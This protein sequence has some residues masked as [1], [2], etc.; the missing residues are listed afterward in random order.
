M[1]RVISAA[2]QFVDGFTRPSRAVIQSMRQMGNEAIKAG[3]QIQNA[4]KTITNAGV[5]VTKTITLP[6]VGVATA[7]VKTAADFE[8]AMSQVAAVSGATGEE[9]AALTEKAKEMG[10]KTKFSASESAAAMN[11]M[12]MAGWKSSDMIDGIEGIMNLA[13]ASGEDLAVTSDI[14]TDALTAFGMSANESKRFAD[15]LAAASSNANT[16]VSMMGETFKYCAPVAGALGYSVEDT[17]EAIG[18]MANSGIKASNAGTAMRAMLTNLQ[19]AVEFSGDSFG[20]WA[21]ETTNADGSMRELNEILTD[22]R[23]AFSHMTESE[24]A[25]NAEALVGKTGMSGFLAVMNAAPADIKKLNTAITN[26]SGAAEKMANIMNDNL[27]GQITILK[28]AIE[29]IAI[30]IGDKLLPY[31]KKGVSWV[32]TAADYIN[33]LSDAQVENIMKWAGIASAVG[34]AVMVFG[35]VVT[36][37]G[38]V[39]STFGKVIKTVASFKGVIGL[40]A[41]PAGIVIGVLAGIALAAFLII[42][43]WEKVKGFLFNVAAWFKEAFQKSGISVEE[44]RSVFSSIGNTT[45]SIAGKIWNLL[46]KAAGKFKEVFGPIIAVCVEKAGN[47]LQSVAAV[48]VRVFYMIIKAVDGGLKIFDALLSFFTGAFSG[49]WK[50][51][52]AGFRTSLKN[53]F[54][55]DIADGIIK[56]FNK[57]L[58]VIIAIVEITKIV[59]RQLGSAAKVIFSAVCGS[60]TAAAS[61]IKPVISGLVKTFKGIITFLKGVFL[62]DW[63]MVWEGLKTIFSGAFE[64]LEGLC[65]VPINAVIGLINGAIAGINKLGLTIPEW[66]PGIGGKSFSINIPPIP[67]LYKGTDNWQGGMAMIHDRGGEIVD[68]PKG[69]R[70]YPHDKSIEMARN[71]G[72]KQSMAGAITLNIQKLADKIEVRNDEDI[73]R[74]AE[75]LA[76]KL[77]KTAFNGG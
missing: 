3:K 16:N 4:G 48:T 47:R 37:V 49:N 73:D 65:K 25:A 35:K 77:K 42:K 51:A 23:E 58:P 7:A 14:V 40:I 61:S 39:T 62:G 57:Y 72:R 50:S 41:S 22:C 45:R 55:P 34:P 56:A 5:S 9:F 46:E 8:S 13:A 30:T 64:A 69:S 63:G 19:G 60:V 71:E 11:Y 20:K 26:S 24:K 28:S 43:N 33:N 52:A 6:V 10:A 70:V 18:L 38:K 27:N 29:G 31:V 44:F 67:M 21:I 59:L 36:A 75:K 76:I 17:A 53:I 54:P 12:A 68:L 74:I 1:G 32:Q 15:V 2:I 66:V